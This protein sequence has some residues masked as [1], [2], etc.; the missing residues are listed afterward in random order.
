M[1]QS[2][3]LADQHNLQSFSCGIDELDRWL[4]H[5]ARHASVMNTARTFVWIEP[6]EVVVGYYS[7][8]GHQV[9][10]EG[11]PH[12]V[13]RGSPKQIPSVLIGKLALDTKLQGD[14]RKLGAGLLLDALERVLD[15]TR[16]VAARL[17]VVD[18]IDDR[19]VSYYEHFGFV[20]TAPD[21]YR[22][23]RKVSDIAADLEETD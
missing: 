15:A 21:S 19:A 5:Y 8:A 10:R 3:P 9:V 16:L 22:L 23:I 20:R 1:Y 4:R 17:V 2:V 14:E 7:L 6:D 18:A 12:R 11:L 13:A